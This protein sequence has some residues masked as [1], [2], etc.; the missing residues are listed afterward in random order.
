MLQTSSIV[1]S[2]N[3]FKSYGAPAVK[4]VIVLMAESQQILTQQYADVA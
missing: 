1:L 2:E 3:G 4:I